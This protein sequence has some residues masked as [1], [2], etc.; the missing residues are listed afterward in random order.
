MKPTIPEL[1]GLARAL[2]KSAIIGL[3]TAGLITQ[4]QC[5]LLIA[6][7]QLEDA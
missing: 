5:D 7:H 2:L 1:P 4:E 3:F 6:L